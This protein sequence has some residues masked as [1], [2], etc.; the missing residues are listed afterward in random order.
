[1][2]LMFANFKVKERKHLP[3]IPID[4]SACPNVALMHEAA[5]QFQI[6]NPVPGLGY[7][8]DANGRQLAWPET[9]MRLTQAAAVLEDSITASIHRFPSQVQWWLTVARDDLHNGRAQL[10]LAGDGV[11]FANRTGALLKDG[12]LEYGYA[13]DLIGRQCPVPLAADTDTM[14][15]PFL[16]TT[17][18]TSTVTSR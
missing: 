15:Y 8:Y 9:Q 11:D 6:A 13:G 10:A 12:Q 18:P 3:Q 14:L 17:A 5:N 2:S 16:R 7:A 1:M 4:V